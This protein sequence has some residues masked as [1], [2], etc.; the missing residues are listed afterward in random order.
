[1]SE[2]SVEVDAARL[3]LV[4]QHFATPPDESARALRCWP[5]R[6]ICRHF[7][8]EYYLQKLDFLVRYPSYLAYELI[9]LHALGV[10]AAADAEAV[11]ATVHQL[12]RAREPEYRTM[13]FRR[14]W[15][16][17][18][19]TIDR[20]EAWWYAR[21]LV[22]IGTERRGGV[23]SPARPQKHFFLTALGERTAERLVAEV[24]HA[25]W[26]DDRIQLVH[27]FYGE[28]TPAAVKSVQYSHAPYRDAQLNEYIP[29]LD[30]AD[31]QA[32]FRRVFGA[33]LDLP[34]D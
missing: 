18:Y 24:E 5:E 9:E 30:P 29:D 10:A 19:E 34:Y 8:P 14:F 16:G 15:R 17:A 33:D 3:L 28:L 25:R 32:N 12:V 26:Y 2:R 20:V 21:E 22:F 7:T 31:V 27:R 13:P 6:P 23:G 11:K 1:V 4:L